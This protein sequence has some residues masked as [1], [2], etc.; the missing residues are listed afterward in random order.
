MMPAILWKEY[1]E[2]RMVWTVLAFIGA[3]VLSLSLIARWLGAPPDGREGLCIVAVFLV[4]IY[5]LICGAMMLAGEHENGTLAYLDALP[6]FRRRLW[7]GKF[8]AGVLLVLGQIA[9]L[10]IL[11][12]PFSLFKN[13]NQAGWT[14]AAML[15]AGMYGLSWGM[16]F[17]SLGRNVINMIFLSLAALAALVYATG[18]L[19]LAFA[20]LTSEIYGIPFEENLPGFYWVGILALV[21]PIALVSSALVFT[22]L[23]RRRLRAAPESLPRPKHKRHSSWPML[24]W[25]TW[26]Q[27]RGFA[28]GLAA[29]ALFLGFIPSLQGLTLW[30][31]AT[32]LVGVLCGATAFA[33]EQQGSY[34]FLGDQ[35][36]PLGRL[37]VVKVGVRFGIAVVA[38][39]L[40]LAPSF[41]YTLCNIPTW[42]ENNG[43]TPYHFFAQ[44]FHSDILVNLGPVVLF[45]TLWLVY[46]FAAGCLF[47]LLF[48]RGLAAGVFA[49]L[50]SS[51]TAALWI[52]S[53]LAGGL[54]AWQVFGP[55]VLLLIATRLLMSPWAAGRIASW[56]TAVR[57]LPFVVVAGL[58]IAG[59]LW[60]RVLEIPN[61]HSSPEIN[62]FR[63]SL[64]TP[65]Q[66]ESGQLFHT[67]CL[68]FDEARRAL[69]S[70]QAPPQPLAQ[71]ERKQ[72]D[73]EVLEHG[74]PAKDRELVV[75]LDKLYA[76]E[77]PTLLK[78]AADLPTSPFDDVR[79]ATFLEPIPAT[80]YSSDVAVALALR[81]LQRQAAGDD[82][83]YVENLRI[84]LALSRSLRDRTF[85]VDLVF[86]RIIEGTLLKGLDRWLEKL[87]GKPDLIRQALA[88]LSRHLDETVDDGKD[89]EA[90]SALLGQNTLDIP[91]SLDQVLSFGGGLTWQNGISI[92]D[93]W[94]QNAVACLAPWEQA[95]LV[96]I[97]RLK[98]FGDRQQQN[99]LADRENE[100]GT[101]VQFGSNDSL[102]NRDR[103][104]NLAK[105]PGELCVARAMQLKLALRWFQADNGKPAENLDNLVPKYLPSIPLD[106]YDGEP[107]RYRLSRGE[108]IVWPTDANAKPE[109]EPHTRKIPPGQGVLWSVGKD[110]VDNG[111]HRQ[112]SSTKGETLPGEDRIFLVPLPPKAK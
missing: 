39:M 82:E 44:V 9:L 40:V 91:L 81:G 12:A 76:G 16:L 35:R 98:N 20:A 38:A 8:V 59:G 65:E 58:W 71:S 53:L 111:G 7:Q 60:Y 74:W 52:P 85:P 2:H 96:R 10:M 62:A 100:L 64:P 72:R 3:A 107:F 28:A 26:R 55:P 68:R 21:G 50:I 86:G 83:A 24:W 84:G 95:R 67:A 109:P 103:L 43:G 112:T 80:T 17:S 87:H 101:H 36:L 106:P 92:Q 33:D 25:L 47:G 75:R 54:H 90:I 57:L 27:A 63:A 14:L 48:R 99:W 37:W 23:D 18:P 51:M 34:R 79:N 13:W 32:L 31:F 46:G 49:L 61:V 102:T 108:E 77:W 41:I 94:V 19:A 97:F 70:Q 6:G 15:V 66:D 29:F 104:R 4:G 22:G 105:Q 93:Q 110:K 45:L 11:G 69:E 30:P 73:A 56:T 78:Q 42:R 1:R 89:L 88:L 5:A